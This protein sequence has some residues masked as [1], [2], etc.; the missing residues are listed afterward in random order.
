MDEKL[1]KEREELQNA[2]Q[3]VK[4]GNSEAALSV[5][6]NQKDADQMKKE[7][8]FEEKRK[9]YHREIDELKKQLTL[10]DE[11][12][13][14]SV[15][16]AKS[17]SDNAEDKRKIEKKFQEDQE[18][19]RREMTEQM[20][21]MKTDYEGKIVDYEARLE[22]ALADKV[23]KM[24]VL[25]EEV[26]QEYADRMDE[27]RNMYKEEMSNQVGLEKTKTRPTVDM[28]KL[29]HDLHRLCA[30][31][32]IMIPNKAWWVAHVILCS[33]SPWS[34]SFF[35]SFLGDFYSTWDRG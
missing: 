25:R 19:L 1:K 24:L 8:K 21:K 28:V 18:K 35:F 33:V 30:Q 9:K 10:K 12:L 6:K 3:S 5:L 15:E 32:A 14:K 4:I 34:K 16:T 26:E 20:E 29:W 2:L 27:L 13:K 7:K 11:Q 31:D 23:E 22:K 17:S